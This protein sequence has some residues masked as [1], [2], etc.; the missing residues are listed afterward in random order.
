MSRKTPDFALVT[1]RTH[2]ETGWLQLID[3]RREPGDVEVNLRA[4]GDDTPKLVDL[5][6][7][8]SLDCER[9]AGR[10]ANNPQAV[11]AGV[12]R[13]TEALKLSRVRH[14]MVLAG[15]AVAGTEDVLDACDV[16]SSQVQFSKAYAAGGRYVSTIK[17][18][19]LDFKLIIAEQV[20][21]GRVTDHDLGN[22]YDFNRRATS[23][24]T[25]D[26]HTHDSSAA[27]AR[28]LRA[29]RP[30]VPA[31]QRWAIAT[32]WWRPLFVHGYPI[33]KKL[34]LA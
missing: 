1:L 29:D 30:L 24:I 16:Q 9:F 27:R 14:V 21:H 31:A 12:K 34:K 3:W 6:A 4:P 7:L 5:R 10:I 17:G 28:M 11:A 13:W 32:P 23:R 8:G 18:G 19:T 33:L 15:E 20:G 26:V 25:L 22:W 2:P